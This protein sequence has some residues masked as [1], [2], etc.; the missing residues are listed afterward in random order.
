MDNFERLGPDD[1]QEELTTV[2]SF[3]ERGTWA[4]HSAKYR[5]NF[6]PQV[7]RNGFNSL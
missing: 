3:P 1:F 6:A 5:G 7:A 2:W 4:T